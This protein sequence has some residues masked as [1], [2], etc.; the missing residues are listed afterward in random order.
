MRGE[1]QSTFKEAIMAAGSPPRARGRANDKE[2]MQEAGG[3]TPACAG[4]SRH[5]P[6]EQ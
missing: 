5:L 3:I 4:K 2:A 6:V 1:E